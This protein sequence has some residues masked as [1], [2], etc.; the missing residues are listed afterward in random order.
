MKVLLV[1]DDS[2]IGKALRR[3]LDNEHMVVDW[4]QSGI[5][6]YD[7]A[8]AE[9]YDVIVL[10]RMLP[11]LDGKTICERIR[12]ENVMS[13]VLMLTAKTQ[14]EDRV[15]G[16][17]AGA[18][19]YLVKPFAF[20]ELLARL[21]A[22]TRRP[23]SEQTSVITVGSLVVDTTHAVVMRNNRKVSL[24]RKEYVLLEYLARHANATISKEKL[25]RDVWEYDTDVLENTVEVYVKNVR[26]KIDAEFP[27][28][29][30]LLYTVRGF[31]YMLKE[32]H[33]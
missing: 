26:K 3:G 27:T 16:L 4:V 11:G 18:D 12:K 14:I 31:G 32:P 28:E 9:K 23:M 1:E 17:D 5:E 7:L 2:S 21:H 25:I 6:G 29:P 8:I 10:D 20:E 19:D 13:P 30:P 24:T 33:V 15:E 22:L